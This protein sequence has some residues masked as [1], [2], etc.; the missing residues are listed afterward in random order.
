MQSAIFTSCAISSSMLVGTNL[1]YWV[2]NVFKTKQV[3]TIYGSRPNELAL[4]IN[5]RN[6]HG[7]MALGIAN[8]IHDILTGCKEFY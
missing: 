6:C 3:N 8:N 2:E 7:K 1:W 4:L 5:T